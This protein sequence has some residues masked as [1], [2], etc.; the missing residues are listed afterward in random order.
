M[1]VLY[2]GSGLT[3]WIIR[4]LIKYRGFFGMVNILAGKEI[5]PELL[6]EEVTPTNIADRVITILNNNFM[7][8]KMVNEL[9]KVKEELGKPGA[10]QRAAGV[11]LE[12]LKETHQ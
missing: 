2:K 5:V 8:R 3:A 12:M 7:Y 10:S 1:V 11:L 6:Q 4:H 9:K